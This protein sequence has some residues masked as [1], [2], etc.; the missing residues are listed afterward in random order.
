MSEL[1]IGEKLIWVPFD[2]LQG[3]KRQEGARTSRNKKHHSSSGLLTALVPLLS[4]SMDH[5]SINKHR[6]CDV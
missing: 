3:L 5:F 2:F 1:S 6:M 4:G